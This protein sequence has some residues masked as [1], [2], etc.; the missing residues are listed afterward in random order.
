MK[1]TGKNDFQEMTKEHA[2][3]IRALR[4]SGC[5]WGRIS[6]IMEA[7]TETTEKWGQMDGKIM[8]QKA[9]DFYQDPD[10]LRGE[11]HMYEKLQAQF[12]K[13]NASKNQP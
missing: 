12:E 7:V 4:V 5:T 8:C 6:E 10:F 2:Q 13:K 1:F 9:E 11:K 3:V